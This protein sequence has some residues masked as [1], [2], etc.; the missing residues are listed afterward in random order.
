MATQSQ[1]KPTRKVREASRKPNAKASEAQ[2]PVV[3]TGLS[4]PAPQ[5]RSRKGPK[6][7]KEELRKVRREAAKKAAAT[8]RERHFEVEIGGETQ[9][10]NGAQLAGLR[11]A[12]ARRAKQAKNEER[13]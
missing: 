5:T 4:F 8:R 6:L 2:P 1:S 9:T 7:T 11:A 3:K 10:V 12:V 13:A